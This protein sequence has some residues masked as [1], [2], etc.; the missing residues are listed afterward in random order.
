MS[1]EVFDVPHNGEALEIPWAA[2]TSPPL[3]SPSCPI[4]EV[5]GGA[6]SASESCKPE[7]AAVSVGIDEGLR[8]GA[9]GWSL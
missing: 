9:D 4:V 5:C 1:S 2:T 3:L 8:L 6:G 7:G